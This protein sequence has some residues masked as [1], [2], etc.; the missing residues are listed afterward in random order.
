M[1]RPLDKTQ[2]DY[3]D[4]GGLVNL[5][6]SLKHGLHNLTLTKTR[7]GKGGEAVTGLKRASKLYYESAFDSDFL[8]YHARSIYELQF[9]QDGGRLISPNAKTSKPERIQG[10]S[11]EDAMTE[12]DK[13]IRKFDAWERHCRQSHRLPMAAAVYI[14]G[15]GLNFTQASKAMR[16]RTMRASDK[17]VKGLSILG[18]E[19]YTEIAKKV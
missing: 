7:D 17:T 18:L 11:I 12:R 14:F 15:E 13:I 3:V 19:I 4:N 2:Q 5:L 10:G 1:E 9:M 16:G 6:Q 8:K